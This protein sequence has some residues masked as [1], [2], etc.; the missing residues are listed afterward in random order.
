M[1]HGISP[2]VGGSEDE[3]AVGDPVGDDGGGVGECVGSIVGAS[4]AL[5]GAEET[6]EVGC[7]VGTGVSNVGA[8][9]GDAVFEYAGLEVG[10][11]VVGDG[12]GTGLG[13]VG[14]RHERA[15]MRNITSIYS[16]SPIDVGN[17]Q[18]VRCSHVFKGRRMCKTLWLRGENSHNVWSLVSTL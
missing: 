10:D 8:M 12:V 1:L 15:V 16:C 11:S 4:V 14:M 6:I 7:T 13:I 2:V 3:L 5:V 9:E 18:N 17:T